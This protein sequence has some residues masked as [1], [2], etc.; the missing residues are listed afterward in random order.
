M[1]SLLLFVAQ[2]VLACPQF[3]GKWDCKCSFIDT[4]DQGNNSY[5]I[6]QE[7]CSRL[8]VNGLDLEVGHYLNSRKTTNELDLNFTTYAWY[9][10]QRLAATSVVLGKSYDLEYSTILS[11]RTHMDIDLIGSHLK[12]DTVSRYHTKYQGRP[13]LK[14][15][16]N[17]SCRCSRE[18]SL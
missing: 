1:I 9:E 18:E 13:S 11:G 17:E 5:E 14:I 3:A 2:T 4:N 7:S 6:E 10:G 8:V 12:I 15:N 16:F